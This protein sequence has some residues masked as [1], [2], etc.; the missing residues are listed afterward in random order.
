MDRDKA[1]DSITQVQCGRLAFGGMEKESIERLVKGWENA[2][3]QEPKPKKT[4]RDA[5]EVFGSL[6]QFMKGG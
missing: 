4:R 1:I 2:I 5:G 6:K 3:G